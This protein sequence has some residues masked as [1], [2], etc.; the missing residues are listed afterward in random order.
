MYP[1]H[2]LISSK[3]SR[4][5]NL[6]K[7]RLRLISFFCSAKSLRCNQWV[8]TNNHAP[9]VIVDHMTVLKYDQIQPSTPSLSTCRGSVLLSNVLKLLA[10]ILKKQQNVRKHTFKDTKETCIQLLGGKRPTADSRSISLDNTSN[11]SDFVRGDAETRTYTTNASR[12]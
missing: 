9:S 8:A 3:L 12:G 2:I 5:S 10:N 7:L 11:F 1:T 4:T 6:V